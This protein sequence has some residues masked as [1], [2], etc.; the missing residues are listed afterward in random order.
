M[1]QLISVYGIRSQVL[2]KHFV[3]CSLQPAAISLL[4]SA[5]LSLCN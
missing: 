3:E 1:K 2:G 5:P 4:L